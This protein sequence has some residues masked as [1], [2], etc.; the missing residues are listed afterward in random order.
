MAELAGALDLGSD[1]V[2]KREEIMAD[3]IFYKLKLK[4]TKTPM[5]VFV[6]MQKSV[7]KKG[8]TKNWVCTVDEGNECMVIDFGD[9]KSETFVLK[10]NGKLSDGFC[11]VAFPMEGELFDDEKKSEFRVFISMLHSVKSYCTMIEVSDDYDV[12]EELFKSLDYTMVFRELTD[13][14]KQRLERLYKLGFTNHED[15]LLA[16]FAE[17]LGLPEDFKWEDYVNPN[18][19]LYGNS[20]PYISQICESYLYETSLL[21]KKR[22]E[23]IYAERRAYTSDTVAEGYAF[24]LGVGILFKSYYGFPLNQWGRGAQVSK[25]FVDKF[26]P[27]FKTANAYERCEL[28]YRLM[29]SIYDFCKF[30]YVGKEGVEPAP[31]TKYDNS[32]KYLSEYLPKWD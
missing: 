9:E 24:A 10:F 1:S 16:I 14:E 17:D 13:T 21:K 32:Y 31:R 4:R 11:K 25:F 19:Q 22:M 26:L 20:F 23:E 29:V 15:F 3:T 2:V 6:K 18:I 28:A 27:V 5:D 12:A 8:P 7:K 30:V